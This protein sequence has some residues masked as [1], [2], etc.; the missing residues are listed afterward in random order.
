MINAYLP[1][2]LL[3]E[4]F[5]YSIEV[6]Q[7]QSGHLASVCRHWRST[8]TGIASLWSTLRVGTWTE[9]EQVATWLQR[10]YPLKVVIDTQR[11]SQKSSHTPPFAAL[12][13]VLATTDRWHDLTISSFP[14]EDLVSQLN[15]HVARPMKLLKLLHVATGCVQSPSLTHL[16]ELVP[17]EAPLSELRL[18]PLFASTPFLQPHWHPVLQ[19]LTVLI[20]NGRDI[21]EQFGLLPA[22]TQLQ[23]LGIDHLLL[24]WYELNV[25]LPLVR[26][27]Q[28][29]QLRASSVQWMAGRNFPSLE[30]CVILLPRC[31]EAVQHHRLE[32]PSCKKLIYH[33]YPM[34]TVQYFHIPQVKAMELRSHDCQQQ[35]VYQHLHQ[36][37]IFDGG[38]SKL[39]TL[40]LTLLWGGKGLARV[41][42]SMGPLQEL[43]LSIT[44]FSTSWEHFLQSLA[45]RPS[46]EDWP[47]GWDWFYSRGQNWKKW[48][49]SQT[50]H[51]NILPSLKFLGIQ[52]TKGFS[53]TQGL[54][55]FPLFRF[56]AWTRT[57]LIPPLKHLKVWEGKGTTD[58]IVV[59]YVP[60][61]YLHK[62]IG[63][64]GE[65]Y[66]EYI[67]K[68]MVTKT[69]II[70]YH[71]TPFFKQIHSTSILTQLQV[72]KFVA[73]HED[74]IHILPW[75]EQIKELIIWESRIPRYSLDV[76][77]PLVH[78][79]QK[80]A[81]DSSPISWML[82]RSFTALKSCCL[83]GPSDTLEDLSRCKGQQVDMPACTSFEW[84]RNSIIP[85]P[86]FSCP[87]LQFLKWFPTRSTIALDEAVLKSLHNFILRCSGLQRLQIFTLPHL[88]L[89]LLIELLFSDLKKQRALQDIREVQVLTFFEDSSAMMEFSKDMAQC[90]QYYKKWWNEFTVDHQDRISCVVDIKASM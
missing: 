28:K 63:S 64:V 2:E 38:I 73:L 55:N 1:L 11:D 6:N 10:A 18:H 72:L 62:Y 71:S 66:D 30:E 54:D 44:Y 89:N 69:M 53:N 31:W 49:S 82:G 74:D 29:L 81:V 33:G 21:H 87:N 41:L 20:V 17:P 76:E 16:L 9:E 79:L 77:L 59:D 43:V 24:P 42:K 47:I 40:H 80:L 13:D 22:F 14:P 50:W 15:F 86:F 19:N 45:A 27:L 5:L 36:L 46:T 35:R 84:E 39:T 60:T 83:Y 90:E 85:F 65:Y 32:M 12:Q 58:D 52:C 88:G 48:R 51:T 61:S 68:G 56:V 75:L 70:D 26:T 34:T 8:I 3:R 4:V 23:I 78:T 37:C 7:M 67:V 25:N 57:H